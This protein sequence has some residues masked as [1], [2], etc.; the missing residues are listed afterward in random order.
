MKIKHTPEP[1]EIGYYP[2]S[3]ETE[4]DGLVIWSPEH[5]KLENGK[6]E[7]ICL[8]SPVEN[9]NEKDTENAKRITDCVNAMKGIENPIEFMNLFKKYN[10]EKLILD[11]VRKTMMQDGISSENI[12]L[13]NEISKKL[14]YETT[15]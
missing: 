10:G 15:R 4:F 14:G 3:Q 7:M 9:M 2:D 11:E 13:F 12:G 5:S 1:W 8:V 6:Y